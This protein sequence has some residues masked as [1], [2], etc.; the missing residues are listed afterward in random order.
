MVYLY[1]NYRDALRLLPIDTVYVTPNRSNL[2]SRKGWSRK[3]DS[4]YDYRGQLIALDGAL[5][6]VE[7]MTCGLKLGGHIC[8]RWRLIP[9]NGQVDARLCIA[10][11]RLSSASLTVFSLT[12]GLLVE[13]VDVG[14]AGGVSCSSFRVA[15]RVY[16][17]ILHNIWKAF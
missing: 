10:A 9:I 2:R 16:P 7:L 5:Q 13:T 14:E 15:T 17:T 6:G 12:C 1:L 4:L 11:Q 3:R 8:T